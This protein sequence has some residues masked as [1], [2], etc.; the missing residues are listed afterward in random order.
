MNFLDENILLEVSRFASSNCLVIFGSGA[1]SALL[2]GSDIDIVAIVSHTQKWEYKPTVIRDKWIDLNR[3]CNVGLISKLESSWFWRA[4][5]RQYKLFGT[6]EVTSR[7][8]ESNAKLN[9]S[10]YERKIIRNGW[11]KLSF[12]HNL[13][14]DQTNSEWLRNAIEWHGMVSLMNGI[15]Q[16]SE[17]IPHSY[18]NH[19]NEISKTNLDDEIIKKYLEFTYFSYYILTDIPKWLEE[20]SYRFNNYH[21]QVKIDAIKQRLNYLKDLGR[22]EDVTFYLRHAIWMLLV[23]IACEETKEAVPSDEVCYASLIVKIEKI[24][25]DSIRKCFL[26]VANVNTGTLK[27]ELIK[28]LESIV[29]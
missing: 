26:R 13:N 1:R 29:L 9:N 24:I 6:S 23:Y 12:Y 27:K 22:M 15:L 19:R 10:Y 16:L 8:L 7:I 17:L 11:E 25:P 4:Q 18:H 14:A 28:H 5:L 2:P 20:V 3:V 21:L